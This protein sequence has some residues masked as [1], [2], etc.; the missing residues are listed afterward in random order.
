VIMVWESGYEENGC[1]CRCEPL[2]ALWYV[3]DAWVEV[4]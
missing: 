2:S 4:N 1:A 3:T